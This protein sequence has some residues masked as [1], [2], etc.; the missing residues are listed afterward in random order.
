V[1]TGVLREELGYD[2][3]V[4][5]DG[6][7][8]HAISRTVGHAEGAVLALAAGVDGLCVGGDTT[9]PEVLETMVE[10]VVDA[11]EAGRLPYAR[12][13]S[14]AGRIRALADWTAPAAQPSD[15]PDGGPEAFTRAARRAVRARGPVTLT[16][17]PVVLELQDEPSIAAGL[18][19]WGVGRP[20]AERLPGTTVV[21]VTAEGPDVAVL[22][23]DH[24]GRP[25]VVGVRGVRRRAWQAEVVRAVRDLRPD[26]VVV[27]HEL[28]SAPEVLGERYVLAYGAALG[29][30]EAAADLLAGTT[31]APQ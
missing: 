7:D 15:I 13:A 14:A 21:D 5:T 6:L 31:P 9:G 3:V 10:A 24:P 11:V 22:L 12:L 26:A 27:D 17:A 25:V 19:P 28:P 4:F 20:L 29:S 8:M 30:A 23:A 16:A 1:V 18:V 2:G